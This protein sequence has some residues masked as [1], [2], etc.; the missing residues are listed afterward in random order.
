[1]A[2]P[3]APPKKSGLGRW[4]LIGCGTLTGLFV[5]GLGGCGAMFYLIYKSTDAPA[6]IGADYLRKAP[7][8]SEV[9]KGRPTVKRQFMGWQ[10]HVANDGGNARITYDITGDSPGS[11]VEATVWLRRI[12]GAWSV[13][14]ARV[15]PKTGEE[16]QIG[17]P[18]KREIDWD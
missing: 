16:L 10:V 3:A 11:A 17:N 5:L 8:I 12:A 7:Q 18:P 1:V 14:G 4:I 13:L 15:Q 6:E 9:V 2:D